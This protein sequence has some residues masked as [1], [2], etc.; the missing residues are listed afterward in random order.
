MKRLFLTFSILVFCS[1][2]NIAPKYQ[3]PVAF[4]SPVFPTNFKEMAGSDQWKTAT[5]SDEML[6]GNWW[7][8]FGDAEL[9]R[10]ETLINV[11]NQ[12]VKLAEAQFR[13]A[14]AAVDLQHAGFFPS[15]GTTPAITETQGSA[16]T[17][18]GRLTTAFAL[19]ASA[20]W[21][22]DLFGRIRTAVE[23]ATA[24]AQS[25]AASLENVRL[26]L[27]STLA[28]D[29]FTLAATD[30]QLALLDDTIAAYQRYLQLTVNRFNGGVAA[31]SDIA[32]A[33]TQLSTAQ[34]QR[35]D[36]LTTRTQFE[37]AIAVLA[38]M[39]PA[40]LSIATKTIPAP[41]PEIPTAVP[42]QLLER[43]PDI[44][45]N[46]R[47]VAVQNA[48]IGLAKIAYYPLVTLSA[49]AGLQG[50]NVQD[51]FEWPARFWSIGPSLNQTL[52]D[53][54]RRFAAL[55]QSEAAYDAAVATYRQSVL[56]AFEDVEDNLAA[57]RVLAQEAAEQAQAVAAAEDSLNLIT[58]RY[59][60]GTNSYL[61][62]ITTQ[63]IALNDERAAVTILQRRMIAAVNLVKALGGG[64]DRS[65][66]PSYDQLRST[67][68]ADPVNTEN[69]AQPL[70]R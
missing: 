24:N 63:T 19:P 50:N 7:E 47:L 65:T 2:C 15:I 39:P 16:S 29:Y 55:Q 10:L 64:W 23:G 3:R 52:F 12:N 35:T 32:L 18:T 68:M 46:E 31:R 36:L 22:V 66:I 8:M 9:N 21:E 59:K 1:A 56:T 37:H 40:N 34:A 11:D 17:A 41:P 44:A 25:F 30:M 61:D 26:S 57:L 20:S 6:R 69:V 49:S 27:Q 42:S 43:R 4:P 5:P 45:A 60:A 70:N 51:I 62:V 67:G 13:Q 33:Q 53:F 54:G 58:E 38:G 14:R 48:N 28:A